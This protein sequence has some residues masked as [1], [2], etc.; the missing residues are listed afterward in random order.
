MAT[1]DPGHVI[2]PRFWAWLGTRRAVAGL[3]W[4]AA[5]VTGAHHLGYA[6]SW[7]GDRAT[8][9]EAHRRGDGNQGHAQIDFGGQWVMG[10]MLV[11]GHGRELYHRQ[12]Q[13]EVLRAGYPVAAE[14]AIQRDNSLAPSSHRSPARPDDVTRHDTDKLMYWFMGAAP[15]AWK[16][17]GGAAAA[18]LAA[19]LTGNP[20]TAV[21]FQAASANVVT[22]AVVA[23]VERPAIG[24]PLYPPV[25]AFFYAPIGLIDSPQQAYF[26]FQWLAVG[27]AF[28]AGLGVRLLTRGRVW[29]SVAA[30]GIL[31]YPGCRSGLALGQNPTLSLAI[32]VW[33]WVLA[34]RNRDWAGGAVWGLFAFKPVW[35]MAFFLVP[36]LMGRWK[37]C[38]AMVGTG[39]VLGL[40]T[41]PVVGVQTWF[42]W[43]AVGK[44]AAALYNVN[45]NW[46]HLSRD[47]QGIPRRFLLDFTKPEAERD[48]P[49]AQ[50]LSWGLWGSV[51]GTTLLVYLIRAD[52]RPTGL[53]AA[54]LFLGA[55]LGCYRFMYYDVLLSAAGVAVLLAEPARLFR[56]RVFG[57]H[58]TPQS[59][60]SVESPASPA[61]RDP[62]GS[63]LLGYVNSF[64]LTILALLYL[65][66]NTMYAMQLEVTAGIG[67]WAYPATAADG[68]TAILT[69]RLHAATSLD[70]PW[71]TV[72]VLLLW[73]WCGLRL[74]FEPRPNPARASDEAGLFPPAGLPQ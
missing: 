60:L 11:L 55:F 34:S 28:L 31:L 47:L 54:F 57:L 14:A 65:V 72:L 50:R 20:L 56:T 62:F 5:V 16:T 36:L 58:L 46:I 52:R 68:S 1:S 67:Y 64:P 27:F 18:P 38:L 42:D 10:R 37:F 26:L 35:G 70:Y 12:R 4:I 53:G 63:R 8:A 51:F 74:I 39:A 22:P 73:A 21:A 32:V 33:G 48:S 49:L 19:D 9:P 45:E 13:W 17:V 7:F 69:P 43:L 59:P 15:P 40:L 25:H 71:D 41:L 61:P 6:R 44:E 3:L 66:D 2:P 24:G 23:E 30:L 29:W